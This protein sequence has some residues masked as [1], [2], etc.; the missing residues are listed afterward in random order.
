MHWNDGT[1]AAAPCRYSSGEALRML[2]DEID[3]QQTIGSWLCFDVGFPNSFFRLYFCILQ[4]FLN[5]SLFSCYQLC[6]CEQ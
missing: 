1:N 6:R 5:Q 4:S 2:N 3:T